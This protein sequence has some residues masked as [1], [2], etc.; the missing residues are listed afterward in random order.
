MGNEDAWRFTS[1]HGILETQLQ[2]ESWNL[3]RDLHQCF[4]LPSLCVGD[5]NEIAKTHEKQGGRLRPYAEM[6]IFQDALDECGL[7]DLGFVGSKFTWFKNFANGVLVWERLDRVVGSTNWF[8][9]FPTTKVIPIDYVTSNHKPIMIFPS[10]VPMKSKK[11]W[12]LKLLMVPQRIRWWKN[13]WSVRINSS[14]GVGSLLIM[15]LKH[16]PRRKSF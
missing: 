9:L 15:L 4:S 6:K 3:L 11:P 8:A 5:S 7:T 16:W 1:F 10:G 14:G 13:R 2:M 12:R